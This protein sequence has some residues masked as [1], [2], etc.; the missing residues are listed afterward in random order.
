[1]P[2]LFLIPI[3][4]LTHLCPMLSQTLK[5]EYRLQGIQDAASAFNF[6][7]DGRF[8]FFF[9]YGAV[10][11]SATGTY[12]IEGNTLTLKSDKQPGK[13]FPIKLEKKQGK[14]YTIII[15]HNNPY[16]IQ[17]IACI[18]YLDGKENVAFSNSQG[19]IHIDEKHID[20]LS[21][22]HELF[23]DVPS[24]IKNESNS[25]NYFEVELSPSLGEVTFQ[26]I[27]FTVQQD[28]IT[29]EPNEVL[30]FQKVVFAKQ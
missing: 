3:L 27:T 4:L 9:I 6:T 17:N 24:T 21:L 12:A 26:G 7:K 13:D 10:D 2:R 29:C 28:S 1:M 11:R 19:E 20:T 30:P 23:P 16:L 15:K 5:G 25:N 22:V 8:E 18:Y 14:G